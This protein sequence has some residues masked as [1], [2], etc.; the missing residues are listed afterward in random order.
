M[1]KG[2]R[3]FLFSNTK[4]F[5]IS[6]RDILF[7]NFQLISLIDFYLTRPSSIVLSRKDDDQYSHNEFLEY[8]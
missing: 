6:M 3:S 5:N 1:P 8:Y 2:H 4:P 7:W